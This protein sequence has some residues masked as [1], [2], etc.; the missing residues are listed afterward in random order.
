T[1]DVPYLADGSANPAYFAATQGGDTE[2]VWNESF[3]PA[4]TGGGPSVIYDRPA[5]QSSVASQI[6]DASGAPVDARG[7]PDLS[8]N[9]AVNGGVLVYASFFPADS[10]PAWHIY[11][12]T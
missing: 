4:A 8:W 10:P 7:L 5:W 1:S 9:A 3:L 12:G 2:A 11:G 6:T